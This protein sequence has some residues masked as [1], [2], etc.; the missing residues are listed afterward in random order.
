MYEA[1]ERIARATRYWA[2]LYGDDLMLGSGPGMGPMTAPTVRAF[3][4]DSSA[5]DT[6]KAAASYVG[7]NPSTWSSGT[8]I[9]P[10]RAI[11]KMVSPCWAWRSTRG[12][13]EAHGI[14]VSLAAVEPVP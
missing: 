13:I 5:V 12:I 10:S 9:P 3:S 11:T 6:A 4:G 7:M 2:D 1:D 8:V 14:A